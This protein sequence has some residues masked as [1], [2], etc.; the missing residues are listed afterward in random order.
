MS[1]MMGGGDVRDNK[2]AKAYEESSSLFYPN[3]DLMVL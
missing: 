1:M 3:G 2:I